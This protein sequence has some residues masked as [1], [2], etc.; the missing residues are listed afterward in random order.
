MFEKENETKTHIVCDDGVKSIIFFGV[1]DFLF[2][3][4]FSVSR[5]IRKD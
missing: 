4:Q 5:A 2:I 1:M 3:D